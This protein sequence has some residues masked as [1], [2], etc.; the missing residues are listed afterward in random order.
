MPEHEHAESM[1]D[2]QLLGNIKQ[3]CSVCFEVLFH[4]Y[5]RQVYSVALRAL[6]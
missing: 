4:R 6:Y 1:P 2:D 5:C 3:G